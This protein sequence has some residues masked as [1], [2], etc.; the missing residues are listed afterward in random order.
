[1]DRRGAGHGAE[2]LA[3]GS[4]P[5]AAL[6]RG[7]RRAGR[8]GFHRADA[9]A[10]ERARSAL[11]ALMLAGL[12]MGAAQGTFWTL[13]PMF[14]RP[15]SLATGFAVINMCGNLAGLVI[16]TFIGWVRA[17]HGLLRWPGVRACR[18][19]GARRGRG[20][21]AARA[22]AQDRRN[23]HRPSTRLIAGRSNHC[24]PLARGEPNIGLLHRSPHAGLSLIRAA[25]R[26]RSHAPTRPS[27]PPT[28]CSPTFA[29]AARWRTAM[30]SMASG[31]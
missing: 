21:A 29:R 7:A 19:V 13:P 16:P 30:R 11:A 25:R 26:I 6:A 2:R 9:A 17:A 20:G 23:G 12:A 3:F 15:A 27:S 24:Y 31:P 8:G 4:Q 1:M 14:L 22:P 28:R 10:R 18:P 5:G